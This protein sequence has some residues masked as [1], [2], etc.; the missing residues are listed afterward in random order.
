MTSCAI[1]PLFQGSIGSLDSNPS[2][3]T[4]T[5]GLTNPLLPSK[6]FSYKLIL[7]ITAI[8]TSSSL[9]GL[10]RSA[11]QILA[12]LVRLANTKNPLKA[13]WAYKII[14]AKELG[15]SESTVYRG[16]RELESQN[17]ITHNAQMRRRHTGYFSYG[18]IQLTEKAC[19][20]LKLSVENKHTQPSLKIVPQ[21]NVPSVKMTVHNNN[22]R[23]TK[24]NLYRNSSAQLNRF[25]HPLSKNKLITGYLRT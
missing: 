2:S 12:L 7:A 24:N 16:L 17:L 8:T 18:T 13:S 4:E 14:I 6:N 3:R 20:T 21:G 1:Q 25:L 22:L 19:E 5:Q 10:S 23:K 9:A 15:M 11:K